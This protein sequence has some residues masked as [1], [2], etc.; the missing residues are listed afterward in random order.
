MHSGDNV[1]KSEELSLQMTSLQVHCCP[2]A[3]RLLTDHSTLTRSVGGAMLS[4]MNEQ[5]TYPLY[6]SSPLFPTASPFAV[7]TR[8]HCSLS[9]GA[10]TLVAARAAESTSQRLS[11][12][13]QWKPMH[14]ETA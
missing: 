11:L 9:V 1:V 5:P 13:S 3:S 10:N 6:V 4:R 8:N 14:Q 12:F 2:E 7:V